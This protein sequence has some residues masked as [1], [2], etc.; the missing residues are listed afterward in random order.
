MTK[1]RLRD[2]ERNLADCFQNAYTVYIYMHQSYILYLFNYIPSWELTY[3][4]Q[5]HFWRWCSSSSGG[6]WP[7]LEGIYDPSGCL[8]ARVDLHP[9]PIGISC[10]SSFFSRR[11]RF[12]CPSPMLRYGLLPYILYTCPNL[13]CN[14]CS[15]CY[16][17]NCFGTY[18]TH[19]QTCDATRVQSATQWTASV[20]TLHMPKPLM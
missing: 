17:M 4:I 15:K 5:R 9:L 18:F 16:A 14:P 12:W 1:A 7:F 2:V 6:I 13:W 8:S 19:A 3:P 10:F 11:G 20:H